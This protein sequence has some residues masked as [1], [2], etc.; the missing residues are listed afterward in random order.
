[1]KKFGIFIVSLM[2]IGVVAGLLV[3]ASC[4]GTEGVQGAQGPQGTEGVQGPAGPSMPLMTRT[5]DI[6]LGGGQI[7]GEHEE[8]GLHEEE[9]II[10]GHEDE[11]EAAIIGEFHRWEPAVLIA[12]VGDTI[13]L[14]VTNPHANAH[15]F[16]LPEFGVVT[17]LLPQDGTAEVEFIVDKAGIFQFACGLPY[18]EEAGYCAPD[19][20]SMVGYFIVLER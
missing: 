18:N 10:G 5:F 12:D 8:E 7:I 11:E 13:L 6:V 14:T 20:E 19:H 16:I 15:S 1:M 17:P 2:L 3:F 9:E 4:A